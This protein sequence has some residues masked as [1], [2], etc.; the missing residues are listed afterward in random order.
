[1]KENEFFRRYKVKKII[2]NNDFG[3]TFLTIDQKI[4]RYCV[5]KMFIL[6]KHESETII[7]SF[8][9]EIQAIANIDHPLIPRFIDFLISERNDEYHV[10]LVQD[11]IKGKNLDQLV[12][13]RKRF[14]EK[15]VIKIGLALC[16]ILEYLHKASPSLFH[17]DIKPSNI[18]LTVTKKVYL[19]DFGSAKERMLNQKVSNLGVS[20]LIKSQNFM[21]PEQVDGHTLPESDIYSL[22]LTFIYALSHKKPWEMERNGD[23][24]NFRKY[25]KVSDRFASIIEKMIEPDPQQRYT[26]ISELKD[27]LSGLFL[28]K[29]VPVRFS[30][31]WSYVAMLVVCLIFSGLG[32][33]NILTD[34]LISSSLANE[35]SGNNISSEIKEDIKNTAII[36]DGFTRQG[37]YKGDCKT[38][39]EGNICLKYSDNYIWLV[40]D[41]IYGYKELGD[42]TGK[43]AELIMV[44]GENKDYFHILGTEL[45][46][47]STKQ[48]QSE[49][50]ENSTEITPENE[51]QSDSLYKTISLE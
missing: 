23:V 27:D 15:D 21:A 9:N 3:T 47:T 31:S 2:G 50:P 40:S 29:K 1:M 39:P 34:R 38:T 44:Q 17:R 18:L 35:K 8:K 30:Y 5:V 32:M 13:E 42:L 14:S 12:K 20:T 36:P 46:M 49:K 16:R 48:P 11:Y 33:G 26:N 10:Y 22:G 19:I 41:K 25:V 7:E 6:K 45:I 4:N 51:E 24:I 37:S 28:D 43:G